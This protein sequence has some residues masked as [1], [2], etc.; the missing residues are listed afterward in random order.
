[1]TKAAESI[2]WSV[3]IENL[4]HLPI[5]NQGFFCIWPYKKSLTEGKILAVKLKGMKY[6]LCTSVFI[7]FLWS[8]QGFAGPSHKKEEHKKKPK[9]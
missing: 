9:L 6:W 4:H 8:F 2:Q 5:K 3:F 7:L 1:M